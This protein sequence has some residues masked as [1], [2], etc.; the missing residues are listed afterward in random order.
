[1]KSHRIRTRVVSALIT[2]LLLLTVFPPQILSAAAESLAGLAGGLSPQAEPAFDVI[3]R[4][5]PTIQVTAS[6]VI[7]V[8]SADYQ[9]APG[10]TIVRATPSGIPMLNSGYD[11]QAYAGESPDYG[12]IDVQVS[13]RGIDSRF[14]PS[15]TSVTI[16]PVNESG[17]NITA[18]GSSNQTSRHNVS[19]GL[20]SYYIKG[21]AS[22][23]KTIE[24][25]VT[26]SFQWVNPYSYTVIK[27]TYS[28]SAFVYAEN[29]SFPAGHWTWNTARGKSTA[30]DNLDGVTDATVADIRYV[31]RLMGRST[32]S[33]MGNTGAGNQGGDTSGEAQHG[34]YNFATG[35]WTA[36]TSAPQHSM[37]YTDTPSTGD[38]TRWF[39]TNT[40]LD[41]NSVYAKIYLDPSVETIGS[42]GVKYSMFNYA[43]G[44]GY[45]AFRGKTIYW[46]ALYVKNGHIG[47]PDGSETGN[48]LNDTTQA[49]QLG[50][51]LPYNNRK[52][53]EFATTNTT[54]D[55]QIGYSD[56]MDNTA[57][58][59][60]VFHP[61]I[62][63]T[64]G[65]VNESAMQANTALEEYHV[66]FT[67]TGPSS[68]ANYTILPYA[69][70]GNARTGGSKSSKHN[71]TLDSTLLTVY[72]VDKGSL[73]SA[74]TA[75][76]LLG[77][78]NR[79]AGTVIR[80][81]GTDP[82]GTDALGNAYYLAN[83]EGA[84]GLLPQNWFYRDDLSYMGQF[85]TYR[86]SLISANA[87]LR[88]PDV[89]NASEL[90]TPVSALNS[91][92]G[93]LTFKAAAKG[94]S[95]DAYYLGTGDA[96]IYPSYEI[97]ADVTSNPSR[98]LM[99]LTY[100]VTDLFPN[101]KSSEFKI[102]YKGESNVEILKDWWTHPEY[103]TESSRTRLQ[104]ALTKAQAAYN[105][106]IGILYQPTIDNAA[107]ELQ[108]AIESLEY[109]ALD[110][111]ALK[112]LADTLVALRN[113]TVDVYD[114][115]TIPEP[116]RRSADH[117]DYTKGATKTTV[118][119]YPEAFLSN[120]D[121]N[122]AQ[123]YTFIDGAPDTRQAA[124]YTALLTQLQNIYAA[125]Q[126]K[127]L[128]SAAWMSVRDLVSSALLETIR[129]V[130]PEQAA[131]IDSYLAGGNALINPAGTAAG[132]MGSMGEY[133]TQLNEYVDNLFWYLYR[134]PADFKNVI[135]A[136]RAGSR[137]IDKLITAV[138][139][140][141]ANRTE[142]YYY[143]SA[144][145]DAF[146]QEAS[147][148]LALQPL[149]N[150][151]GVWYQ[152]TYP[153]I[154]SIAVNQTLVSRI[155]VKYTGLPTTAQ[156]GADMKFV[157]EAL[158]LEV[159]ADAHYNQTVTMWTSF[160]NAR[161]FA[162]NLW[163]AASTNAVPYNY[164]S[165]VT[166]GSYGSYLRAGGQAVTNGPDDAANVLYHAWDDLE[167][168]LGHKL[169]TY[170]FKYAR[171]Q[172][173]NENF[174]VVNTVAFSTE[175]GKYNMAGHGMDGRG[176]P[177]NPG[178]APSNGARQFDGW[179]TEPQ[180][181]AN[182][183]TRVTFPIEN[184]LENKV[185]YAHY[186]DQVSYIR[187]HSVYGTDPGDIAGVTPDPDPYDPLDFDQEV[188]V[189]DCPYTRQ[190][191]T[192]LYWAEYGSNGDIA[193]T[194]DPSDENSNT[195]YGPDHPGEY[196]DL[197]AVWAPYRPTITYILYAHPD[198]TPAFPGGSDIVYKYQVDYNTV[199]SGLSGAKQTEI[200]ARY[201]NVSGSNYANYEIP[202][203]ASVEAAF[204]GPVQ[205]DITISNT[206]VRRQVTLTMTIVGKWDANSTES[207]PLGIKTVS[208]PVGDRVSAHSAALVTA[209][210]AA[211]A[212]SE[213]A[214]VLPTV[215]TTPPA[216]SFRWPS[217][218][219]TWAVYQQTQVMGDRDDTFTFIFLSMNF[220]F[221][222][223]GGV[224]QLSIPAQP[225][226]SVDA[227][228]SD[229][230]PTPPAGY[231][232]ESYGNGN[233]AYNGLTTLP[234][235]APKQDL[236]YHLVENSAAPTYTITFHSDSY[237]ENPVVVSSIP[238]SFDE[239]TTI[240]QTMLATLLNPSL[241]LW[242]G[243]ICIGFATS[244]GASQVADSFALT[245]N[246]GMWP[247][248]R[249]V[250]PESAIILHAK[251]EGVRIDQHQLQGEEQENYIYG[252]PQGTTLGELIGADG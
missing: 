136:E 93:N 190:G 252:I 196:L 12:T 213:Y 155:N 134:Y 150:P 63:N 251:A 98:K 83:Y 216:A 235:I 231:H 219:G 100:M 20:Y 91:A 240:T 210:N 19:A 156:A 127:T 6:D 51:P 151:E 48:M 3:R 112:T 72:V 130:Q 18:F 227:L 25:R 62:W 174:R 124:Q 119:V 42:L 177:L 21:I 101:K 115:R 225:G 111:S 142:L 140:N 149:K 17:V 28:S 222:G 69:Y 167:H 128:D 221:E 212:A 154:D 230:M 68:T 99:S 197:Y 54:G 92:Y 81:E 138:N 163:T 143:T 8:A 4:P 157:Y 22:A 209:I 75:K 250:V 11:T 176:Q 60:Y 137:E 170:T 47:T 41:K 152:V 168:R 32:Y 26:V 114:P 248:W 52:P 198:M 164:Q 180:W 247:V 226:K 199:F 82:S 238:F 200:A 113:L 208:I 66:P 228:L 49:N 178:N 184:P 120:V 64:N 95:K 181:S 129:S 207:V 24:F 158:Q 232:W 13:T 218:N 245:Q 1:M 65:S 182:P 229:S 122:T 55:N 23:G 38:T 97:P 236:Y 187:Y 161:T 77:D 147:A 132:R 70:A 242:E 85:N 10:T 86:A 220:R 96:A 185:Y 206:F 159:C 175:D 73:R 57:Y 166:T 110:T 201:Q 27:E 43:L 103:Y 193:N 116:D 195:I 16:S 79:K 223:A 30:Q 179:W 160:S 194:F 71:H 133:Q 237:T 246:T 153:L 205:G 239:G 125:R 131:V 146:H 29:I 31:N 145:R 50:V 249:E 173:D 5:T 102:T 126:A 15:I 37:F 107:R 94:S 233:A 14:Q 204:Q 141:G 234:A 243:H 215:T 106:N 33:T 104:N 53:N 188:P 123:A 139:P 189:R 35:N 76:D 58:S 46:R 144:T 165:M 186:K 9:Y 108:T 40:A 162:R 2:A 191:F 7:R 171:S 121:S 67:G 90:T 148:V 244:L 192:F 203:W 34:F 117:W 80:S 88:K 45:N 224:I 89:A 183:G 118:H 135:A 56:G 36:T 61:M 211:G 59:I 169:V 241:L 202:S 217:A 214:A 87:I 84:R 44:R 74:I 39:R 172:S 105:A 109:A 78:Q